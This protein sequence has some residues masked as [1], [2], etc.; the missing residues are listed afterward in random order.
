MKV[1]R[2]V[3]A[4]FF[5]SLAMTSG[6]SLAWAQT[7]NGGRSA[8]DFLKISPISRAIG[9]G[10][11]YTALGDDVG[12]IYYNPAGLASLLTSELNFTYLSLY[13]DI[14]YE[15]MAFAYPL[16]SSVPSLGTVALGVNLLQPGSMDRTNDSG[17]AV[18][19]FSSAYDVFTLAYAKSFGPNVN[20]GVSAKLIQ[21]QIDT[22]QISGVAV[23]A[24][25]LFVPSF[26]GMRV[27]ISVKNLGAQAASFDLPL[28]LNAGI[29]YRRYEVFSEQDDVA[30]SAEAAFPI[31][32][33]EDKIGMRAGLEYN[34]K[35]IGSRATLRGGYKFLDSDLSG[36]GLTVGAGYALDFSGASV[37]LDY[38]FM[39]ADIFGAAHR[40]SLTSK[41]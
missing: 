37:F 15:F 30:V 38:A 6:G 33:I 29:S 10:E 26:D 39:P 13:Q 16:S 8:F 31:L 22:V 24:G 23:D 7:A 5:L 12:A 1:L 32:P 35:W 28:S 25:L 36:E 17:V 20:L 27:G 40:I 19:T 4:A 41:F 18:G 9:V 3:A 21:Q 14:S 2:R 11:A 34:F